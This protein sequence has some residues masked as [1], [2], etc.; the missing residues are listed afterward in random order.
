MVSWFKE[1]FG[2][3]ETA[4]AQTSAKPPE[5][6]FDELLAQTPAGADG[7]VLQPFWNP[8]L[9][10]PGP[11][12]RGSIIG[13]TE[14]HTRAH[15]YRA[16][17][18]GIGYALRAGTEQLERRTKQPITRFRVAGGGSQSDGVMQV[19]AD[20]LNRPTERP[21]T[22]EASGLGA[23]IIGAVALGDYANYDDAVKKMTSSQS[24]FTPDPEQ[25]A[26]YDALYRSVYQA[27]YGRL[28]PLFKALQSVYH[29]GS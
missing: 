13:F 24:L 18:E 16:I 17:I 14:Q 27:Q 6:L 28:K 19:L 4:R 21:S 20:I 7:L 1:H 8:G 15:L 22:Y 25:A 5:A 2:A 12:A 11:E 10:E 9:G 26:L 23:A 29:R 3:L